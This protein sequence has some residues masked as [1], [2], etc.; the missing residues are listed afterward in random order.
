MRLG[1]LGATLILFLATGCGTAPE[2]EIPSGTPLMVSLQ[3]GVRS[4]RSHPGDEVVAVTT[5]PIQLDDRILVPAGTRVRGIVTSA[6]PASS[7]DPATLAI[8]FQHLESREGT[9]LTIETRP[10]Q[11]VSRW[12]EPEDAG[13]L[14]P[15]A[16]VA[17]DLAS[18]P[19]A[20]AGGSVVSD[21][22]IVTPGKDIA[23]KPGQRIL[24][25][26]DHSVRV[27]VAV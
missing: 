25:R 24:F 3:K 26:L 12:T 16:T 2:I 20:V 5:D 9:Q 21:P 8:E 18:R 27:S 23:L 14:T 7:G 1:L 4:D 22:T 17:R 11:L 15:Y 19:S 13:S 10:I 6:T